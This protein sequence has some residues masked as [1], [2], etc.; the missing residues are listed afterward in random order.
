MI[1]LRYKTEYRCMSFQATP[2]IQVFIN[3]KELNDVVQNFKDSALSTIRQATK[4]A[5]DIQSLT[6]QS[7]EPEK[8]QAFRS[9]SL[10]LHL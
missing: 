8:K 4:T 10:F 2:Y 7:A 1:A 5:L 9:M 3:L 6:N